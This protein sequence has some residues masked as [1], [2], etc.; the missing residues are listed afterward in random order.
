MKIVFNIDLP[1]QLKHALR[2][3][4]WYGCQ[5]D[6]NLLL[7]FSIRHLHWYLLLLILF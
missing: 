6:L 3:V 1:A 7:F 4:G 5:F 2:C